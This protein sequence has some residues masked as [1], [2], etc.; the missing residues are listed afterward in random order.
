MGS[1]S[2]TVPPGHRHPAR[3]DNAETLALPSP[4]RLSQAS[5]KELG[6]RFGEGQKR[7]EPAS[8]ALV[9]RSVT[10]AQLTTFHHALT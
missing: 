8:R 1:G 6:E 2:R 7:P 4:T 3:P 10:S 9:K 5:A